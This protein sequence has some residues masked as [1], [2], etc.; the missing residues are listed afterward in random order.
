MTTTAQTI[1]DT[2]VAMHKD[3]CDCDVIDL[4]EGKALVS[5]RVEIFN[6][7]VEHETNEHSAP[8]CALNW[9]AG[10]ITNKEKFGS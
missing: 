2:I 10:R 4:L 6:G 3:Y 5:W 1:I 7:L 8:N 9:L